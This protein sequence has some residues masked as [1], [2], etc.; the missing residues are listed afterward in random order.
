QRI[1]QS[2]HRRRLLILRR[3]PGENRLTIPIKHES[4]RRHLELVRTVFPLGQNMQDPLRF[5]ERQPFEKQIVNQRK[6]RRVESDP[7]RK[8]DDS[9]E[10]KRRR[11]AKFTESEAKVVHASAIRCAAPELDRPVWRG[12]RATS[13]QGARWPRAKRSR[14]RAARGCGT[15]LQ[16]VAKKAIARARRRPR[17]QS[18]VR[19]Q[20]AS[21]LD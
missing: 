17:C 15:T 10:S 12:G 21:F 9:D 7:E 8:R 18:R 5:L 20:P 14:R 1:A 19:S 4:R 16:R 13:T 2:R 6:D 3:K 11:F